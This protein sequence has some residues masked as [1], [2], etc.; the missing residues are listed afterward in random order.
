MKHHTALFACALAFVAALPAASANADDTITRITEHFEERG[1]WGAF[2][3][4]G[5]IAAKFV[6]SGQ[7]ETDEALGDFLTQ[8]TRSGKTECVD[9]ERVA[10]VENRICERDLKPMGQASLD[11][12]CFA[13]HF[14]DAWQ[15]QPYQS[16]KY[17]SKLTTAAVVACT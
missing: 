12:S 17:R 1:K 16:V 14:A 7:E 3:D 10:A 6:A 4:Y 9:R 11:C 5:C 15:K 13:E 2:F 8:E